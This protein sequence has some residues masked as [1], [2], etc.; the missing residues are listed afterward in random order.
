[1]E[2][3]SDTVF[4]NFLDGVKMDNY[5]IIGPD[6]FIDINNVGNYPDFDADGAFDTPYMAVTA[7]LAPISVT[8][9]GDL[10]HVASEL[11]GTFNPTPLNPGAAPADRLYAYNKVGFAARVSG[12]KIADMI[13]FDAIY[14]LEGG[15][16]DTEDKIGSQPDGQG[17][18]GHAFGLFANIDIIENLGIG[19]GYS[20]YVRA[21]EKIGTPDQ[22]TINPYYNGIDLRFQF[23]GVDKL[24]VTF[25]NNISF[26][27]ANGDDN[28][29]TTINGPMGIGGNLVKDQTESYLALY[30]ALGAKYN[31]S[32]ALYATVEVGNLLVSSTWTFK[33][34]TVDQKREASANNLRAFLGAGYSFDS[35]VL[36][37]SGLIFDFISAVGKTSG[38]PG[39]DIDENAGKFSFGIPLRLKIEF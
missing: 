3:Y 18:W 15:D 37:E 7:D 34:D 25:N 28:T 11:E 17:L 21:Q 2:Q 35:H 24:A 5:G 10:S 8:L 6:G 36:F 4:N 32:D 16:I 27:V 20:G 1:V 38:I 23:T 14:K 29:T 12:E 13:N 26:S 31:V 22:S 33:N 39:G 9:A 19:V 30:N